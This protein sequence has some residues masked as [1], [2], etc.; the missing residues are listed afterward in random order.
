M[1]EGLTHICSPLS[2]PWCGWIMLGLFLCG[3]LSEFFQAGVISQASASLRSH[4][5]RLYRDMPVNFMGQVLVTLFRV[6]TVAMAL[7]LCFSPSDRFSFA[8][9]A[10]INGIII[11]LLLVKMLCNVLIDYTFQLSRRFGMVYEH[12][13]NIATL[14]SL[15]LWPV[16]LVLLHVNNPVVIRWVLGAVVILFLALWLYRCIIQYLHS[17]KALL[18]LVFY[19]CTVELVP[20]ALLI[21][22]SEKTITT[23]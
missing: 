4:T 2:A 8:A 12:Y 23:I 10:A 9:Y 22:L 20:I 3:V 15:V 18:Y 5:E 11:A 16:V 21:Y 1:G 6:G 7:C 17:P 14:V 13:S 19:I